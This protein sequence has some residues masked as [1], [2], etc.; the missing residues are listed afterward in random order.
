MIM[1]IFGL[2]VEGGAGLGAMPTLAQACSDDLIRQIGAS[3][4]M[5]PIEPNVMACL[6]NARLETFTVA[7]LSPPLVVWPK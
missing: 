6:R 2:R 7:T 3:V 1:R 4:D 5:A